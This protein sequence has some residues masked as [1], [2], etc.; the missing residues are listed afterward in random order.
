MKCNMT[1]KQAFELGFAKAAMNANMSP[2]G[3][4]NVPPPPQQAAPAPAQ[5]QQP[6]MQPITQGGQPQPPQGNQMFYQ[7]LSQFKQQNAP[8][9]APPAVPNMHNRPFVG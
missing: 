7:L 1:I 8:P 5:P 9:P 4:S 3:A 6:Q 2:L